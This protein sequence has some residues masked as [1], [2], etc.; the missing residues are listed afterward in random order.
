MRDLGSD[1]IM[2]AAL[3]HTLIIHDKSERKPQPRAIYQ[4]MQ[5]VRYALNMR[6]FGSVAYDPMKVYVKGVDC[7]RYFRNEYRK[8]TPA[9]KHRL[10]FYA[11]YINVHALTDERKR[12]SVKV[13]SCDEYEG[14]HLVDTLAPPPPDPMPFPNKRGYHIYYGSKGLDNGS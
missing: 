8:A 7:T 12:C 6:W 14:A 13:Y 11:K 10:D 2:N 4:G 1:F 5:W 9:D 3:G